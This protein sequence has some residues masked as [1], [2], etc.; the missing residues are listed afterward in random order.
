LSQKKERGRLQSKD[1]GSH[2]R[3]SFGVRDTERKA[4]QE[5]GGKKTEVKRGDASRRVGCA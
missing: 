1:E 4:D 5:V 3:S 2:V